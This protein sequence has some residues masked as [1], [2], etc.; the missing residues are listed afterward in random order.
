[1]F[2]KLLRYDILIKLPQGTDDVAVRQKSGL[3]VST[4]KHREKFNPTHGTVVEMSDSVTGINIGEEIFFGNHLWDV[5]KRR[6]FG[7]DDS[8]FKG[9]YTPD[10]VFAIKEGYDCYMILPHKDVYF[11]VRDG[12]VIP[13]NE[14]VVAEPLQKES[15]LVEVE[16]AGKKVLMQNSTISEGGIALIDTAEEN[17]TE[18][19]AVVFAAPKGSNLSKGDTIYTLRHC[20]LTAEEDLNNPILPS[21]YFFIELENIIAKRA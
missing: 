2:K 3:Y 19:M 8:R 4:I 14:F 1:M 11:V 21:K 13:Q 7:D 10:K 20:D 18:N 5:A 17:Y 12:V 6:A 15:G 9:Q 16:V